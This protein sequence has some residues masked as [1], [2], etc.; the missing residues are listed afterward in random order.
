MRKYVLFLFLINFACKSSEIEVYIEDIPDELLSNENRF[1]I[2][3]VIYSVDK[4]FLF[5]VK[6]LVN[7]KEVDTELKRIKMIIQGTTKPFSNFDSDYS[8]TVIKYDYFNSNNERLHRERT[9]L[10]ENSKNIWLHPPRMDIAEILQLSAFPFIRFDKNKWIW[11]L[12]AGYQDY[13]DVHLVSEYKKSKPINFATDFGDLKCIPINVIT[14]SHIGESS[15]K[16]LFTEKYGFVN[17]EFNTIEN[18][19]IILNL[20]K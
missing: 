10:V 13:K 17:L 6:F 19:T 8:Q 15:S 5:E 4:E 12:D 18:S 3:N 2:D 9:G 11:K 7:S 20:I 1:D 16:F 14:K